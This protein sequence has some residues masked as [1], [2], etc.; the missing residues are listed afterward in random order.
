MLE[1]MK[2]MLVD[3][4]AIFMEIFGL[5]FMMKISTHIPEWTKKMTRH[6][7]YLQLAMI[8][9]YNVEQ[10]M[11]DYESLSILRPILTACAYSIYPLILFFMIR[12]IMEEKPQ[13]RKILLL[14]V[15]LLSCIPLNFTTQW[16][17]LVCWFS[18]DN[19]YHGG[20]LKSLPYVVIFFYSMVFLYQNII[21]FRRFNR[22][23]RGVAVYTILAPLIGMILLRMTRDDGNYNGMLTAAI[24]LY[25]IFIYIHMAKIDPLTSLLNRK[26][27]YD[28]LEIR[29]KAITAI[30]SVDMNDLKYFND[31]MGHHAGDEALR[32]IAEQLRNHCGKGGTAYRVGGDEFIILYHNT[33]E[34]AIRG[35]IATMREKLRQTPYTCAFGYA[36]V[37]PDEGVEAAMVTADQAMYADKAAIKV[38]QKMQKRTTSHAH[39]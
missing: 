13:R 14:L 38:G 1:A 8:V 15:P 30:V 34:A 6:A 17:H 33:E 25:Y 37:H 3:N 12:I 23:D 31:N 5:S 20:P 19:H 29:A 10:S 7:L 27:C 4:Y 2:N 22:I 39:F 26:C 9:C 24:M 11:H 35:A 16:T 32:T 28:D 21:Y 36:M 18:E